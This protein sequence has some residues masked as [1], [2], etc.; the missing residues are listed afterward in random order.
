MG[1]IA[2]KV[3]IDA[4]D[5]LANADTMLARGSSRPSADAAAQ[6]SRTWR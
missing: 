3:V 1:G 5:A 2:E 4:M 6:K